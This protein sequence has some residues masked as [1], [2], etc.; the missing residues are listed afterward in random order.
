MCD[1]EKKQ[2]WDFGR[3]GTSAHPR[4]YPPGLFSKLKRNWQC[5]LDEAAKIDSQPKNSPHKRLSKKEFYKL[6]ERDPSPLITIPFDE[7][8]TLNHT[9]LIWFS[10]CKKP[11]P[12]KE[13]MKLRKKYFPYLYSKE[14]ITRELPA[15]GTTSYPGQ[16]KFVD[17]FK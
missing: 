8:V 13:V 6:L 15:Q 7:K 5:F 9:E 11:I 2:Y 3:Q 17:I 12:L 16:F 10:Q 4:Y 1:N 14:P